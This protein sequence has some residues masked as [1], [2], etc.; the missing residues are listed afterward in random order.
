MI[1]L[2]GQRFDGA[3]RDRLAH[4]KRADRWPAKLSK[5]QGNVQSA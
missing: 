4:A 1:A 3:P 2:S 5:R